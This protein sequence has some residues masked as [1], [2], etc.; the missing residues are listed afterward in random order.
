[1]VFKLYEIDFIQYYYRYRY[2]S[3]FIVND[4][5]RDQKF[6]EGGWKDIILIV[7]KC[8]QQTNCLSIK[9][10]CQAT[11]MNKN[12]ELLDLMNNIYNA[13]DES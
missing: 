9:Y 5:G 8:Y 3:Y 2:L 11:I 12:P 6:R 13:L 10:I 4:Y 1:M 7:I